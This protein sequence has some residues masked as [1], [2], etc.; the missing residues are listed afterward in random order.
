LLEAET[1]WSSNSEREF[2][3]FIQ[4][5]QVL[6]N[7]DI[8]T[9]TGGQ[10]IPITL[11]FTTAVSNAQLEMDF[12]DGAADKARASGIQ[13]RKIGDVDSDG[14]GIPDW[15][16]L[17]YFNHPTG[18]AADNSL[19]SDD[20]DGSGMSNLQDFLAGTDPINPNSAFRI[21]NIS[22]IGNDVAVT[23]TTEPNKTNQLE[24]SSILGTNASWFSV[25]PL[26]IGTGSPASQTDFGAATNPPA[27][28]RVLLVP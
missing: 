3:L 26:T 15:W 11:V 19:A 27:F 16:M 28:Y 1:Y 24:R 25:G 22:I 6:S 23:W 21:T 20:A 8:F 2:N 13:V 5:Q 7:F 4:G 12:V 9:T 18:Q 10:N 17:A 14:D